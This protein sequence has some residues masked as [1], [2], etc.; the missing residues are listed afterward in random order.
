MDEYANPTCWNPVPRWI[1]CSVTTQRM[2]EVIQIYKRERQSLCRRVQRE[3]DGERL[4]DALKTLAECERC[5]AEDESTF[6]EMLLEVRHRPSDE[7]CEPYIRT[8]REIYPRWERAAKLMDSDW[9]LDKPNG[10][11]NPKGAE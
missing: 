2:W 7:D 1:L 9:S 10:P 6:L 5:L 8:L 4:E 3:L 11:L